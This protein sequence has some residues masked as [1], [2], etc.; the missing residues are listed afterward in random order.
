MDRLVKRR[1][2][3]ARITMA[4]AVVLRLHTQRSFVIRHTGLTVARARHPTVRVTMGFSVSSIGV[5][6]PMAMALGLLG[7][8]AAG[9]LTVQRDID[10]ECEAV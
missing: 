4:V 3:F 1:A 6:T 8:L 7:L 2:P 10:L 9:I 5:P